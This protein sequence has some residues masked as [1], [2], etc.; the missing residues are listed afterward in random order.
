MRLFPFALLQALWLARVGA[1][2]T[3]LSRRPAAKSFV[4]SAVSAPSSSD[5]VSLANVEDIRYAITTTVNGVPFNL[6]VDTGSADLWVIQPSDSRA[7]S[8]TYDSTNSQPIVLIYGGGNITGVTASASVQIGD[9][10]I[11]NQAIGVIPPSGV[12]V[13]D[14]L[15]LG[16][17]GLVG[18]AFGLNN[19]PFDESFLVAEL[20]PV[21]GQPFLFNIFDSMPVEN[22]FVGM[23]LSRTDDLEGSADASFTV[24]S[25]DPLHAAAVS[26]AAPQAVFPGIDVNGRWSVLVDAIYVGTTQVPLGDSVVQG[27]PPGK[28]VVMMDSGTPTSSIPTAL[29]YAL[30]ANIPGSTVGEV[31]DV[32]HFTV[33]CE[34]TTIM[35]VVIGGVD[36]PI[37]PL[38]LS[39]IVTGPD[40][41]LGV[42]EITRSASPLSA[43]ELPLPA[44]SMSS[45]ETRSCG[46]FILFNYGDTPSS[47]GSDAS[48]QFVSLTDAAS[49]QAD[50][51]AV[52]MQA[53][54]NG[55]YPPELTTTLSGFQPAIPGVLPSF[56]SSGG[57]DG[58]AAGALSGS[59]ASGSAEI[60]GSS[61]YV[62][63]IIG[64][65]AANL[66][67]VLALLVLGIMTY[68]R[69]A[70]KARE[71][72]YQPLQLPKKL[73]LQGELDDSEGLVDGRYSD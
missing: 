16:L 28:L 13:G 36:F 32:A 71:A 66:L 6:L 18:T 46:T 57:S 11:S 24:N 70:S 72:K 9:F 53:F 23:S 37:H 22:N 38:D 42:A 17:D 56:L 64:L 12:H 1:S 45:S 26:S 50:V 61:K 39:N 58:S 35:T 21:A 73:A 3:S 8:F 5:S 49:A 30:Y 47:P 62:T 59:L 40:A 25:L 60:S 41:D 69:T 54:A 55:T 43:A 33:P 34:S 14:I 67:V 20:G 27:T 19:N 44:I 29:W 68:R 2:R 48:I 7:A 10:S 4:A 52:R 65:L 15:E 31:D 63:V 51:T